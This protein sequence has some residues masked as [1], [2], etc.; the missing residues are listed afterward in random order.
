MHFSSPI[1]RMSTFTLAISCL[2][3]ANLSWFM[4]LTFQVP[5]QYCSYSVWPCFYHQS[6]PQLGVGFALAPSLHSFRSYFSTDLQKHIGHLLTL[7]VPLSVSYHFAFS[8][9]SWGPQGKN[10]EVVCHSLLQ[11]TTFCQTSPGPIRLGWP[12]TACLGF[13]ES[14]KAMVLW[15]DWLVFCDYGFSD[16]DIVSSSLWCPL[17]TP[18]ILLR[19]LLLWT[20]GISSRLLQQSAAAAP[21]LGREYLLTTARIYLSM[22]LSIHIHI[23]WPW[24]FPGVASGKETAFQCRRQKRGSFDLLVEKIPWRRG[25]QPTPGKSME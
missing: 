22:Y 15:S 7:G 19:F 4:D 17:V 16:Y 14:D 24:G 3:T 25:W 10:T 2:T 6:H 20:W 1:P 8:Y 9:C 23:K 12:H 5:M 11:W 18:T 13:I 21:Y